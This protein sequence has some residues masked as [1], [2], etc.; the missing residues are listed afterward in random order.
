MVVERA[1]GFY[2]LSKD[3]KEIFG[4]PYK[5]RI[6]A[7]LREVQVFS[8]LT[9]ESDATKSRKKGQKLTKGPV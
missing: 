6:S 8:F 5:R 2:A 9:Q 1:D 3:G 7:Q 4:G